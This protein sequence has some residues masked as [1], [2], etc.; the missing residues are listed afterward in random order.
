MFSYLRPKRMMMKLKGVLIIFVSI[1]TQLLCVGCD[2]GN[3]TLYK[4]DADDVVC[5]H[6]EQNVAVEYFVHRDIVNSDVKFDVRCSEPWVTLV[7]NSK[8][9]VVELH[10]ECNEG[11]YRSAA[12]T[13]SAPRCQEI[14]IT[15]LQYGAP[16]AVAE[17]TLMF[18]FF[19]TSLSR[20]FKTNL[21]DAAIA[22]ET[23]ILGNSNR[24]VFFRQESKTKGYIGEL[25]YDVSGGEC[26]EQRL[27]DITLD[28]D[29]RITP[30]LVG[31][32]ISTMTEIAPAN[33]YGIVF[34]GHGQGWILRDIVNGESDITTLS[35]GYNPWTPS[36][37]AEVTRAFG[38]NNVQVD[39]DELVAGIG[40]S[41]VALDY[42]LFDA[43][44][45][46][47]IEAI[48]DLRNSANYIIASPCEIM[49]KGFPYH[50]TLPYLF[51]NFGE[52]TDYVGAAKS[53]YE[54]Y[55]DEYVGGSRC[56]SV[57]VYECADIESLADATR[58]VMQTA[59]QKG[60]YDVSS[61]QSYEGQKKHQFYDFGQWV[62]VVATNG[63]A[64]DRFNAQMKE[65]VVAAFTLDTF[66]SAYGNYG[67]YP[68]DTEAYSGVTTSAPSE[69]YPNGWTTTN[70]YKEVIAL[71]N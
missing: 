43:C 17:H 51:A 68:I 52:S 13:I 7:D 9:G 61:L 31:E 16:P 47:N 69:V 19:G 18:Y 37:G 27:M 59:K 45:M 36:A 24:V 22:I 30:E 35:V 29:S 48:Y 32:Y 65:C 71:E 64:L 23:G 67:T 58:V 25:C 70:W 4:I 49:G 44:F 3:T 46:S 57:A 62:N 14:T 6:V 53:Y 26:I 20:Y 12:I 50:R 63:E 34:A 33:R 55:R 56:G 21:E 60:E 1:V 42:I 8:K 66:Y 11:K 41:G 28:G 54:Y 38:E 5:T 10:V 2:I 39:I 40:C 15:L